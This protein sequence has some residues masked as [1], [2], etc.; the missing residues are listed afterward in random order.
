M[1]GLRDSGSEESTAVGKMESCP[2]VDG[3]IKGGC[4]LSWRGFSLA[5]VGLKDAEELE[6]VAI[7][8]PGTLPSSETKGTVAALVVWGCGKQLCSLVGWRL[9]FGEGMT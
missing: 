8:S 9:K 2:L 1:I 3:P 4:W 5:D 6:G 7:V